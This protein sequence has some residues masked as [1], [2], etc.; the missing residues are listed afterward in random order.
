MKT[1]LVTMLFFVAG[2]FFISNIAAQDINKDVF[3]QNQPEI[4]KD[5]SISPKVNITISG[6]ITNLDG[7]SMGG[8]SIPVY[9]GTALN[10]TVT[11][12]SDGT[13]SFTI[14]SPY[15][16]YTWPQKS[17]STSNWKFTPS[18]L[19][20]TGVNTNLTNQN[21][22]AAEW[23]VVSGKV[24]ISYGG[25]TTLYLGALL[26]Y[27]SDNTYFYSNQYGIYKVEDTIGWSGTITPVYSCP[28]YTF[29]FTPASQSFTNVTTNTTGTDYL[30][31][32]SQMFT[33]SGTFTDSITGNPI[34]NTTIT[35][36]SRNG[37]EI[38]KIEVTTNA[39][40]QYSLRFLPCWSGTFD[41][42]YGSLL[43]IAP[44]TR[45]YTNLNMNYPNQDF[46]VYD[47][48]FGTPPGWEFYVGTGSGHTNS[49]WNT[50]NPNFCGTALAVGDL[51]GGFY[52]D[53]GSLK[54]G[55]YGEWSPEQSTSVPLS[56]D[57]PDTPLTKEGFSS[58]EVINWR[59]FSWA[60]NTTYPAYPTYVESIPGSTVYYDG[61]FHG[62]QGAP[63]ALSV[64][65][66]FPGYI[67]HQV[68]LPTGWGSISSYQVP[69]VTNINVT[70]LFSPVV[71]DL[72][73][74]Q[75]LTQTYWPDGSIPGTWAWSRTKGYKIKMENTNTLNIEGCPGT[76]NSVSL[77]STSWNLFPVLVNCNTLLTDVFTP[78]VSS[79]VTIIKDVAGPGVFWPEMNINTL[80]I[81]QPGKAYFAKMNSP[82]TITYPACSGNE[83]TELGTNQELINLTPWNDP[84]VYVSSHNIA[85]PA[86]C[87]SLMKAGDFIGA[88]T[89][90]GVCA[91]LTP[92]NNLNEN[93]VLTL[94]GDDYITGEAEG[95]YNGEPL[96][97]KLYRSSNQKQ[98]DVWAEF[99]TSLPSY[100]GTFVTDGLSAFIRLQ[101]TSTGTGEM[102]NETVNFYPNPSTGDIRINADNNHQ[103]QLSVIDL[104]GTTVFECSVVNQK[105]ISLSNLNKG[106]Y[107][108][109]IEGE[110]YVKIEKLVI[111]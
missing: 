98:Y 76:S 68:E 5:D 55:G 75:N 26:H 42:D 65:S 10:Q 85:I 25:S 105:N 29:P 52:L 2:I 58:A 87:C 28:P 13:Y 50:S 45:T 107:F 64:I 86:G 20:Y 7:S 53:N 35:F 12:A 22:T 6:T 9:K 104:C 66:A 82:A 43:Y 14:T 94:Y 3:I 44:I 39:Q 93:S 40:G 110:N 100:D 17:S 47:Y 101:L 60:D 38:P 24:K 61:K 111:K 59:F 89:S 49:V 73:I 33:I 88:F 18:E 32:P 15:S 91:G 16:G 56:G 1:K 41:P 99:D 83:K 46:K 84:I 69:R 57:D 37:N 34:A 67:Y 109:K 96:I 108:I 97:F 36:R 23:T 8:V 92:I 62:N 11:T 30:L 48:D 71:N 21:Y 106:I 79:K 90:E 103:Y 19:Y 31:V 4:Q 78:S 51:I 54:C 80:Q 102:N 77:V 95:F 27:S 72:V 70:A 74:L 63:A 81:L